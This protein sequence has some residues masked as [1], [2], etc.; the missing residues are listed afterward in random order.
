M[1]HHHGY[2]K[3]GKESTH[4]KAMLRN[5]STSMIMHERIKTTL[6]KA[7]ALKSV[8]EK[9]VTKGKKQSLHSRRIV[10]SYLFDKDAVNKVFSDLSERFSDRP[11]GYCRILKLGKRSSDGAEMASLE[12][13]DYQYAKKSEETKD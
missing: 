4:R 6:P 7:K 9:I 11:G 3:L 1:R 12:F 5:M 10:A 8:V 2:R 13:V